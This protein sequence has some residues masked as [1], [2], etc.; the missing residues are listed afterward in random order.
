MS[1][2]TSKTF[3]DLGLVKPKV[4]SIPPQCTIEKALKTMAENNVLTLPITSRAFPSKFVYILS[5]LD[6]LMYVV[7]REKGG[8]HLDLGVTVE[9]AMTMAS[10]LKAI[11]DAEMES[12]RVFERDYRDT[13]ESTMVGFAHGLHRVLITD[14]LNTKPAMVLTQSDITAYIHKNAA[15]LQLHEPMSRTLAQL[16]LITNKVKTMSTSETALEGYNRMAA[17]K[18]LALPV[19]D[20]AGLVVATLSA[21]DLR[22]LS[23]ETLPYVGLNVLEFLGKMN[24]NIGKDATSSV[25]AEDTLKDAVQLLV[26]RN[27]HRL[28]ILDMMLRPVGVVSQS[29]VMAAILGLPTAGAAIPAASSGSRGTSPGDPA[30]P[31]GKC[32]PP[33]SLD[34]VEVECSLPAVNVLGIALLIVIRV[35]PMT[36]GKFGIN[37]VGVLEES[38]SGLGYFR[39]RSQSTTGSVY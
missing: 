19:V 26:E 13:V 12:Y 16:G 9:S 7:A 4:I 23:K 8:A 30:A 29:D 27:V 5:T 11:A 6:I 15:S 3:S 28:W 38:S 31:S 21:S 1:M 32:S 25:S 37:V 35:L 20:N 18:I 14:A 22:G 2:L 24:T 39:T 34:L 17:A 36:D 33:T 10:S